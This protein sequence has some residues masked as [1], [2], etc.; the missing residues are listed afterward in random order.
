MIPVCPDCGSEH[1]RTSRIRS[2]DLFQILTL[3]FPVRCPH[4]TMR[5]YVA[6]P[7]ALRVRRQQKERHRS[8]QQ[9]NA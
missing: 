9:S 3:R 7:S 1:L 6:L 4:C 2:T 5:R 8:R